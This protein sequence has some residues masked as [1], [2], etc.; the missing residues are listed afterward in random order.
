M[1]LFSSLG[2]L[3]YKDGGPTIPGP[4]NKVAGVVHAGEVVF[5]QMDVARHGGIA[6]VEAIRRGLRGYADGGA[7]GGSRMVALGRRPE[8][9][10]TPGK[11]GGRSM[12]V[13]QQFINPVLSDRRS[14]TQR[15]ADSARNLRR[16]TRY[17]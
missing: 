16:V 17:A 5:S 6:A 9:S 10:D 15:A 14:D 11:R 4:R 12:N 1:S 7:V 8:D 2:S 13:T 3:G